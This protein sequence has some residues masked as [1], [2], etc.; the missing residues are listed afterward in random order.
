MVRTRF[1]ELAIAA[2]NDDGRRDEQSDFPRVPLPTMINL[3]IGAFVECTVS[4]ITDKPQFV[5]KVV[6]RDGLTMRR[7]A[8]ILLKGILVVAAALAVPSPAH[9]QARPPVTTPTPHGARAEACGFRVS[10]RSKADG[11]LIAKAVIRFREPKTDTHFETDSNGSALLENLRPMARVFEVR[12]AGYAV[13]I[14][15]VSATQPGTTADLAIGLDPG[16]QIHGTIRDANG[17]P[18]AQAGLSLYRS[19]SCMESR[20]GDLA[21]DSQGRFFFDN[22]PLGETLEISATH[23]N[24]HQHKAVRL[25]LDQKSPAADLAFDARPDDVS[26]IVR[27]T[28]PNHQ[29][30]AGAQIVNPGNNVQ[31]RQTAT[32]DAKGECRIDHVYDVGRYYRLIARAKGFAPRGLDF[33]PGTPARPKRVDVELQTGHTLRG[34]VVLIG[35]KPVANTRILFD[36][37]PTQWS[38]GGETQTDRDGRFS[39]DSLT[40]NS[41]FTI[42]APAGYSALENLTL[43]LDR[44]AETIITLDT[45]AVVKGHVVDEARGK[46]VVPFWLLAAESPSHQI[47]EPLAS[48]DA[49]QQYGQLQMR[50]NGQFELN[51]LPPGA[52]LHLRIHAAGYFD[53]SLDRVVARSDGQFKPLEIRLRKI[54]PQYLRT[55]SARLVNVQGKPVAGAELR[56][57]TAEFEPHNTTESPFDWQSIRGGELEQAPQCR[58]FLVGITGKDGEFTFRD[59]QVAGYGQLVYWGKGIAPKREVIDLTGDRRPEIKLNLKA[60]AAARLVVEIDPKELP[61]ADAVLVSYESAAHPA[62]QIIRGDP[63]RVIFEDLPAGQVYVGIMDES[64]SIEVAPKSPNLKSG[65]TTTFRLKKP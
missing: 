27:V 21:T 7:L 13:R 35:G 1:F 19:R 17:R 25:S 44:K 28:G 37:G 14:V 3:W 31:C 11:R 65:E 40:A 41:R 12:A 56:L 9:A 52:P 8:T 36:G 54:D 47:D 60:A 22:A 45:G 46:P 24:Q 32:T 2:Y 50:P 33:K 58:Q 53:Q 10:V 55:V 5:I 26:V 16:G 6:S 38:T 39:F 34:R 4:R 15:P 43:T 64:F 48:M 49:W 29:P 42:E 63:T 23:R 61:N 20:L 59:V 62:D 51:D 57:W 18:I 30:I